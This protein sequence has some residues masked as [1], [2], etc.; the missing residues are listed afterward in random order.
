MSM[1]VQAKLPGCYYVDNMLT[2][3][4]AGKT[5]PHGVRCCSISC[6]FGSSCTMTAQ[7]HDIVSL[8]DKTDYV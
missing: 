2:M 3:A 6:R 1:L 4:S 8:F 7:R 5:A